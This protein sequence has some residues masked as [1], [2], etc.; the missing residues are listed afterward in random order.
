MELITTSKLEIKKSKFLGYY[1]K[2]NNKEEIHQILDSLKEEHKKARHIVYAYKVGSTAG[3]TDD[4]EPSGTAG[5]Q[6][7]N[8]M[9]LNGINDSIII[10]V[11]YFGGTK[12]GIGP[13]SK[14]YRETALELIK[15]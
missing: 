10:V 4:K 12:L 15:K 1:Y 3:K 14:A 11:R 2:I 8:L 7:Y 6:I 9:E 13:L 5:S